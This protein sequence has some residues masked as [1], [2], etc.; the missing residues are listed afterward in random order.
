MP[1]VN[2]SPPTIDN[3][4]PSV[5]QEVAAD[6]GTWT[7][8]PDTFAYQWYTTPDEVT[9]TPITGATSSTFTPTTDEFGLK[10]AV[11][12]VATKDGYSS[13]EVRSACTEAVG[14]SRSDMI[15][16]WIAD[17]AGD[18]GDAVSLAPDTSGTSWN[19]T[20]ATAPSQ[21][22]L[23]SGA[24]GHLDFQ[25]DGVAVKMNLPSLASIPADLTIYAVVKRTG[26]ENL[27]QVAIAVSGTDNTGNFALL[28]SNLGD[29]KWGVFD[30]V[31]KVSGTALGDSVA[32]LL[33]LQRGSGLWHF[34]TNGAADGSV[35][36]DD[37][38]A[39]TSAYLFGDQYSSL[40]QGHTPQ[41]NFFGLAHDT[42]TRQQWEQFLAD[43]YGITL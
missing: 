8:T 42:T 39:F 1:P 33:T 12:V 21:P 11:G 19:A 2:T 5:D 15:G 16:E 13:A 27:Y 25:T 40:M 23:A 37:G 29:G 26:R 43:K 30:S 4:T 9:F 41:I 35:T 38:S 3:Q 34:Y 20:Q 18:L 17:N 7:P 32:Y 31:A 6:P 14:P 10:L 22:L 28:A 24:N 36:A